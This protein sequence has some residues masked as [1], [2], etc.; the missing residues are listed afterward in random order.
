MTGHPLAMKRAL[1][2]R[3]GGW[4]GGRMLTGVSWESN[5]FPVPPSFDLRFNFR[6]SF[7]GLV[8]ASCGPGPTHGHV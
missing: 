3:R 1:P 5:R 6:V 2:V 4:R 7:S 8:R